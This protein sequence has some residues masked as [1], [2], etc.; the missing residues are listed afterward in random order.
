MKKLSKIVAVILAI[1]SVITGCKNN[2]VEE[3]LQTSELE[4]VT[5]ST[6]EYVYSPS[7]IDR[8]SSKSVADGFMKALVY[9]DFGTILSL[10]D[11]RDG[12]LLTEEDIEYVLRRTIISYIIGQP[13]ALIYRAYH[14]ESAG[15][16]SYS[17][18]TTESYDYDRE[19]TL[20]MKLNDSNLWVIDKTLF[21]KS[22]TQMYVPEG[23]RFYLDGKEIPSSYK[24]K[25][26]NHLD[27]Y[28][29]PELARKEH[30]TS[31]VSSVFGEISGSVIIPSYS[32]NDENTYKVG[33]PIEV[34]RQ[35][36]PELLNELGERVKN[37][38]NIVF[39]MMDTESDVQSLNQFITDGK[40][41]KFL[42]ED[43]QAGISSRI[44]SSQDGHQYTD[45]EIL[46]F[47]QNPSYVSYVYSNDT[48]VVNMVLQIRWYEGSRARSEMI[49]SGTK[50]TKQPGGEWLLNDVTPA[51]WR[52]LQS[53]L[54]ESQGVDAW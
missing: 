44:G 41:Y 26:Q 29:L 19:F 49:C 53:G 28:E 25:T 30:T 4:Q 38:Y 2:N 16:A 36:T 6:T 33:K 13:E 34:Y 35:I 31:I 18:G 17:F 37:I 51:A 46:E 27:I 20:N 3:S 5:E 11:L 14:S 15:T 23:V 12:E 1:S 24:I 22:A 40:N 7:N 48:I 32:Y 47:W 50:L 21:V 52:T 10:I 9:K 54:D 43:Y 45:T 39:N 8:N 42:E